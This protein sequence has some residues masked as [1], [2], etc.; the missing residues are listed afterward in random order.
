V[1]SNMLSQFGLFIAWPDD[2]HGAGICNR[3]SDGLQ[4]GVILRRV[5]VADRICLVVKCRVG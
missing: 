4:K 3:F 5:S 1:L 2:E